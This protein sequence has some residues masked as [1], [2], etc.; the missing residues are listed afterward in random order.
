MY[1][2]PNKT[3]GQPL[4]NCC[5][6]TLWARIDQNVKKLPLRVNFI[7]FYLFFI[8][9]YFNVSKWVPWSP[10]GVPLVPKSHDMCTGRIIQIHKK[11]GEKQGAFCSIS[12]MLIK[13]LHSV[14]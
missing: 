5:T 8:I 7:D 3:L 1:L 14:Y 9:I 4:S 10:L 6:G 11:C 13:S 12:K 2:N